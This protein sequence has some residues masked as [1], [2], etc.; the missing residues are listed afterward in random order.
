MDVAGLYDEVAATYDRDRWGLLAGGRALGLEQLRR[1]WPRPDPAV[2]VDLG[3]GTGEGL[4]AL[5]S[6][7]PHAR[8]VGV[9][10]SARMLQESARKVPEATLVLADALG[11]GEHVPAGSAD[12][13]LVHF[14]TTYVRVARL[15]DEVATLLRP[16]GLV[17]VVA[18]TYEAFPVIAAA[19]GEV[20]GAEALALLNPA[21]ASGR[22]LAQGLAEAGL[23]VVDQDALDV[24]VSFASL[25]ELLAWG[26]AS[27]F[28][29]HVLDGLPAER[30]A[31]LSVLEARFPLTDRYRASALLAVKPVR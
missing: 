26:T 19:A 16:G 2:V 10:L 1:R 27:G 24:E 15:L 11:A 14:L 12:V 7:A 21:P 25:S 28:F 4:L 31:A 13:V 6:L 17:S 5:R 9:D 29:A 20:L 30:R 23:A 3:V 22:A 18:T 8:L